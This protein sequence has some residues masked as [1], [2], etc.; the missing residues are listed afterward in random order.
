LFARWG[1][2]RA[3]DAH[4][5]SIDERYASAESVR[6]GLDGNGERSR[7]LA[8]PRKRFGP[9]VLSEL[10][11]E[12]RLIGTAGWRRVFHPNGLAFRSFI[13]AGGTTHHE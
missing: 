3:L 12:S 6:R 1:K 2:N 8:E 5:A 13:G 7:Q 10:D 11:F 9:E 4:T